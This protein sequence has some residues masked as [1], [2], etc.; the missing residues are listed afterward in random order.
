MDASQVYI[1]V[2]ILVLLVV[3]AI[4][5]LVRGRFRKENFTP[6]AGLA[7]IFILVGIVFDGMNLWFSYGLMGVGIILAII[8]MV[9]R[10]RK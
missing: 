6:L 9:F 5:F 8:D 4:V 3:G 10:G 7:F 1:T 2:S